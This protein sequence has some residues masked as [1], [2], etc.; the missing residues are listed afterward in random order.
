[1]AFELASCLIGVQQGKIHGEFR[2]FCA[3]SFGL[4]FPVL[5]KFPASCG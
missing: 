1:M 5:P 4:L 2:G 3:G